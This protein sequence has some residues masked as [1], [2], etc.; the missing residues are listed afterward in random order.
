MPTASGYATCSHGT[1]SAA[2][3]TLSMTTNASKVTSTAPMLGVRR[4]L[5]SR[6]N[7]A[8][9]RHRQARRIRSASS[10]DPD[11][12][13]QRRTRAATPDRRP[14][15]RTAGARSCVAPVPAR[16]AAPAPGGLVE[17][18]SPFVGATAMAAAA[19]RPRRER[20]QHL[21]RRSAHR[22]LLPGQCPAGDRSWARRAVAASRHRRAGICTPR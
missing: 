1:N 20:R 22:S 14:R 12:L 21:R 5:R 16:A 18:L 11:R 10:R 2:Y 3:D 6:K 8:E 15:P 9:Q 13:R 4:R 17:R 19:R 7:D